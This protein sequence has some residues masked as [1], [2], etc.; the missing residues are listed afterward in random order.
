MSNTLY[1]EYNAA[2]G[3]LMAARKLY[4]DAC[5]HQGAESWAAEQAQEYLSRQIEHRDEVR[6]R[7]DAA[8]R[9]RPPGERDG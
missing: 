5:E 1:A 8:A 2:I 9:G 7:Y 4:A 3:A 6:G